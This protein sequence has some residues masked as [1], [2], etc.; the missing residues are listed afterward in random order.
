[1]QFK[2]ITLYINRHP[3]RKLVRED[4]AHNMY[5]HGVVEVEVKSSKEAREIFYKGMH[6][7]HTAFTFLNA[8]S[9]RSHSVFTIRVVQVSVKLW[10][11]HSFFRIISY[12]LMV[13][14]DVIICFSNMHETKKL[15]VSCRNINTYF[16]LWNIDC[17]CK[18]LQTF[19]SE[20][21]TWCA[22][23]FFLAY[24]V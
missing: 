7:K 9:S 2:L 10:D 19:A 17:Y 22:C 8:D 16:M 23:D 11:K 4:G 15:I 21:F 3:Q 20:F 1:M 12:N 14:V 13:C 24:E 6:R 5:V 18:I